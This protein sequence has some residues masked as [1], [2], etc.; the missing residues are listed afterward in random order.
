MLKPRVLLLPHQTRPGQ[1]KASLLKMSFFYR[2]VRPNVCITQILCARTAA[3]IFAEIRFDIFVKTI[4]AF[5]TS[6][7]HFF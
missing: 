7:L 2:A 1:A 3:F 4:L 6:H 5:Y